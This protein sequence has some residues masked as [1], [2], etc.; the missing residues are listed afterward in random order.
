MPY[1]D[2]NSVAHSDQLKHTICLESTLGYS[3][4]PSPRYQPPPSRCRLHPHLKR[5]DN[6]HS[7][8]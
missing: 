8:V 4:W 5:Q 7:S 2:R 1:V 6:F 3:L